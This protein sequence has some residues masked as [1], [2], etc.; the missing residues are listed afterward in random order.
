MSK[1]WVD[2]SVH[3]REL[4]EAILSLLGVIVAPGA[5]IRVSTGKVTVDKR[6]CR[7]YTRDVTGTGE[8]RVPREA[9]GS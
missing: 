9:P 7:L 2:G 8:G 5:V 3:D 4:G 1:D 6:R